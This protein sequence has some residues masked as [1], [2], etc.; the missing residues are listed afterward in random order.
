MPLSCLHPGRLLLVLAL[1]ALAAPAFGQSTGRLAGHI[2]TN[3]VHDEAAH[4]EQGHDEHAHDEHA[5]DGRAHDRDAHDEEEI[6]LP[7]VSITVSSPTL[8]GTRTEY[9]DAAGNFSFSSLPPGTY[10]ID[11]EMEGFLSQRRSEVEVRLNR[12]TEIHMDLE[13][14]EFTGELTVVAQTPMIDPEQVS[15]SQSFSEEHIEESSIGSLNRRYYAVLA[16]APGVVHTTSVD[17]HVFGSTVAENVY[18]IDSVDSSDPV[19]STVGVH[20][21]F[22]TIQ[23][24][25][26]E[27][28]GF[29]ARYGRA[30]GGVVNVVTKSG[31]NDLSGTLDVRYRDTDFNTNGE[32]FD[33]DEDIFEY[34][35]PSFTLGG[36]FQR[37]RLWFFAGVSQIRS[38]TTPTASPTT[39]ALENTNL[40]G[41]V[42]W[43]VDEGWQAVGRYLSDRPQVDNANAGRFTSPDA[44]SRR[45]GDTS[46][47]SAEVL[48]LSGSNLEWH[49][50]ASTSRGTLDVVPQSGDFD[51]IGHFAIGRGFVE[52]VNY[53]EL[54]FTERDRDELTAAGAWFSGHGGSDHEV[55]L[56]ID[57]GDVGYRRQRNL[58]GDGRFLTWDGRPFA[59]QV[60]PH[61]PPADTEG[62]LLTTYLQDTWRPN[63]ELTVKVGVRRDAVSFTNDVGDKV[64]D[65]ARWQPRLGLAWDL[66]GDAKFVA[67]ASWGRFMHPSALVLPGYARANITPR[68]FYLSCSRYSRVGLGVAP[69]RC[70]AASPGER[71]VAN[72]TVPNWIADPQGFDPNGWFFL[73]SFAGEP[74]R[75]ADGLEPTFAEEAIV[76]VEMEVARRTSIGLTYVDKVTSDIFEDTCG[77]NWPTPSAVAECDYYVVANLPQLTRDYQGFLLDIE[78]RVIDGLHILASYVHSESKGNVE[79]RGYA[80]TDFDVYPDHFEN[81]YGFLSDHRKHRVKVNGHVELPLDFVLGFD[82]FW[83]SPYVYTP[84]SWGGRSY[85][86]SYAAPR[87]SL[88]ANENH[89]LDLQVAK[90]FELGR[91]NHF[92]LIASVYNALDDE[93]AIRVCTRSRGC[94][95]NIELGEATRYREP[96]RFEAGVRFEF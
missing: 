92:Q 42:T 34:S 47:L 37:D 52:T 77:G 65:M 60:Q 88:E 74:N 70:M 63:H 86:S 15:T 26:L 12:V 8:M 85:G 31:G 40:L 50:V 58:T 38:K 75:I 67:R 61:A 71:A 17:P 10:T 89:R 49:F 3:H 4:D 83:S 66:T 44:A 22:D 36:P 16:Q 62:S 5:H 82:M 25:N 56:G 13:P 68:L 57:Y 93:Q 11:V 14:G 64:A 7:G 9:T 35:E 51:T 23:E 53:S 30:T 84:W 29:E 48:G 33:R 20:V 24:I 21:N 54:R 43:Q 41:K 76:G 78:T 32:H 1:A 79:Y 6:S 87:G 27:T 28:G 39:R 59:Y 45:D 46:V 90:G 19:T 91:G 73:R 69:E 95:R 72:R 81:R 18:Y 80:S 55:R 2:H 96:R 94:W